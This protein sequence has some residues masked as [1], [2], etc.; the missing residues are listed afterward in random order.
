MMYESVVSF[1]LHLKQKNGTHIGDYNVID[2]I[3]RLEVFEV[4]LY[5]R[6]DSSKLRE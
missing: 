4:A 3:K 6:L 1:C 5:L 2:N